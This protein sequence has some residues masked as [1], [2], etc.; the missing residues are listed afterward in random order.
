MKLNK[1]TIDSSFSTT[2]LCRFGRQYPTDK[3][4]YNPGKYGHAYTAVYDLLFASFRFKKINFG[5]VGILDNQSMICWQNY[6]PYANLYGWD[7]HQE[8]LD[9]AVADKLDRVTYG[10][11][12]VNS[13]ESIDTIL[14]GYDIKF[15]V[16]IDDASHLIVDQVRL[17]ECA[18]K[19]MSP[20]GLMIIEDIDRTEN[21][22]SYL[23]K[24]S[25]V[26]QYFHSVTFI[27]TEHSQQRSGSYNNDKL[28][29][30]SRNETII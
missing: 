22:N 7:R 24:I 29:V 1:V 23:E 15:D 28:L 13:S 4:P 5:E 25:T 11:M 27:E 26:S 6:F 30:L 14:S 9:K 19:Y 17:I 18:C 21:E 3:S 12:N 20:G 10:F 8:Y 2:D 16:L